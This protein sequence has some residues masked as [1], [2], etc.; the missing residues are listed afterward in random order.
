MQMNMNT[1]LI[2]IPM[3]KTTL[4]VLFV[5]LLCAFVNAQEYTIVIKGG[6]VIDP[7]NNINELMDVAITDNK[8]V[9]VAKNIDASSAK[10]VVDAKGLFVTPGLVDIH[11]HNFHSMRNG[12]P[13][14][15]GFTFRSGITTTVDAGSSGW[16]S[17]PT[18]KQEVI[19]Q[20]ETRVLAFL[21]IVGEGYRGG[22][23]EQ[24][25]GDMDAKLTSL[26]ARR[27]RN[28]IVGIKV[29]HYNGPEWIP[30]DR[31]VEA[32]NL[33]GNIPVMIDFGGNNP[34]LSIE[35]LFFDHLRPGDIFTHCFGE[36]GSREAIVDIKTKKIK[37]FVVKAQERGIIFDVGYGG[38]SFAYSQAIP[39]LQQGFF[40]NSISTDMNK[41]AIN[42]S[43]KDLLTVMSKFMALGM[44][45]PA[46]I[47]ATTSNPAKEIKRE[48]LGT[49]SVGSIAD[50]AIFNIR[51]GKF[52]FFDY[53]G[54]K[55]DGTKKLECELTIRNGKVV[56]NLNGIT[57]PVVL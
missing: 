25:T 7:K 23:Y 19:D 28:H 4:L 38:I 17:F 56:Y 5:T 57:T 45:L 3:K 47:R 33:A 40:P 2:I 30:V 50:V 31:A 48:D 18:F 15:D 14:P 9:R 26:V 27:Y 12:D 43:M 55:M 44:D 21:N 11:S 10:Q 52:G 6:H 24:D 37:H 34:P 46:V 8:I 49:L 42:G 13:V 53:T 51:E 20:A 32:G 22:A 54:Y 1:Q 39:A 41:G 16:K 29:A 35:E 36:L